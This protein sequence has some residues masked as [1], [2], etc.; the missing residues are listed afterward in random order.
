MGL[1]AAIRRNVEAFAPDLVHLSAPDLLGQGALKLARRM[2]I[3]AVASLH[4]LFETYLDYYALGWLRPAVEKKLQAFYAGCDYVLTPTEEAARAME[5]HGLQGRVRVWPRGV[6]G[7]LFNPGRRCAA[8][9]AA[10]G[11]DETAPTV[12]YF[13]RLV[14]EK[15][16]GVFADTVDRVQAARPGTQVLV[17]G[18]GPARDW[19]EERLPGACFTGFLAGEA[20]ARAVASGDI[21]L[22]PS[23][24]ETFGNVT[25]EAMAC[26]LAVVG[27]DAAAN[28]ALLRHGETG[29]ICPPTDSEAYAAAILSLADDPL[30]RRRMGEAARAASAAY[31]WRQI[32]AG[33]A[34]V[35]REAVA[36]S[37][38]GAELGRLKAAS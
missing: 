9:R 29:L 18:D 2:G 34:E 14:M 22:N 32:L 16:L 36:A 15:G 11:L 21:L 7:E 38:A 37:R 13:G 26:G 4:T 28:R 30:R 1:P 31:Q 19:M 5:A 10:H 6:D 3:P 20:L 33:V 27:A 35:Y 17:I 8:W 12:V 24:T 23:K 25:L